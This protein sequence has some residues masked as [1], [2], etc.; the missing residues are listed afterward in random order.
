MRR[1]LSGSVVAV[2]VV[3]IIVAA[4][5]SANR[6]DEVA[7]ENEKH[8]LTRAI[9]NHGEWSLRRLRNI[10]VAD[11]NIR[12]IDLEGPPE[13]AHP[14][15]SRWLE[16][17]RDHLELQLADRAEQQQRRRHRPEHL[18]R[19]LFAQLHQPRLQL[20]GAQRVGHLDRAEHLGREER[21]PGVLQRLALGQCVAGCGEGGVAT[22]LRDAVAAGG[23]V[24][25]R[26]HNEARAGVSAPARSSA[27]KLD[28]QS[29]A[30]SAW[31]HTP[32]E[33]AAKALRPAW[34]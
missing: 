31:S 17:M 1:L 18:D 29:R 32:A 16:P 2:A 23:H 13:A 12:G 14:R 10:V 22:V 8:L 25:D 9:A 30:A 5:T 28:P 6:A 26:A 15:L 11:D 21:Q 34:L 27:M 24:D 3:C 7:L 19:A 33:A 20:L 4:L